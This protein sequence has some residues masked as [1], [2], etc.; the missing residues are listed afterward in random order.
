MEKK[1]YLQHFFGSGSNEW[2]L[3]SKNDKQAEREAHLAC[4][5]IQDGSIFLVYPDGKKRKF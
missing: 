4:G 3:D 1:Y 2:L 5:F